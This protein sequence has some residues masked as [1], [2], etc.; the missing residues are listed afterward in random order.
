MLQPTDIEHC[1]KIAIGLISTPIAPRFKNKPISLANYDVSFVNNIVRSINANEGLSDRQRELSIKLV[2]KYV[3]QYKKLGVDVA[4]IVAKPHFISKLRQVDR[5]KTIEVTQDSIYIKFPYN[6][7]MITSFKSLLNKSLY[8]ITSGW[9][10]EER[11]YQV[12]YNEYNLMQI[13]DWTKHYRFKYSDEV[14]SLIESFNN[15]VSNRSKYAIQLVVNDD[16]CEL[17]NAPESLAVWWKESMADKSSINQVV[18]AAD[19]NIDVVNRSNSF[20]LSPNANKILL[21]RGSEFRFN[22]CTITEL[23]QSAEELGFK[24]IAYIVDGRTIAQDQIAQFT[25]VIEH[26][27][28]SNVVCLVKHL[29]VKIDANRRF[30][31]DV[32]FAILDSIQRFSHSKSRADWIPDFVIHTN[33]ITKIRS[34]DYTTGNAPW[35]CLYSELVGT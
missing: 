25:D 24:R 1:M 14:L 18:A 20:R 23:V 6:K 17:T 13:V 4:A 7:E 12:D 22:D 11:R 10:K 3:R 28:A 19:Q 32:K 29:N 9:N 33:S 35:L 8:T 27:G 5:K 15:M 16:K 31:S 21:G 2:A 26:V 30:T 34:L